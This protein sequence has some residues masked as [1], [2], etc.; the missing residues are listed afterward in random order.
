MTFTPL[1]DDELAALRALDTP[2]VCNALE[3]LVPERRG[4]G[5]TVEQLICSY[6]D[7]PPMVGYA[8]TATIRAMH[9]P[10]APAA[11]VAATRLEYYEY[12]EQGPRPTI[13][14]IQ[15][16]D[17]IK[18]FGSFWGEVQSN[19]HKGLGSLGVIT[20]GCVRDIP[21]C[22]EGFQFISGSIKPSHAYV[23]AVDYDVDVTVSGMDVSTDD[24][25]HADMHGAVVIP[26]DVARNVPETAA[27][28]ARKEAVIIGASQKPGFSVDVL[29]EAFKKQEDIH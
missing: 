17:P 26:H 5:F 4:H 6:P 24:L 2:T 23:H 9:P 12:V 19:V 22:A 7:L 3:I 29:R 28:I 13:I 20:D 10:V 15:D 25:I 14:V 27:L 16:L 18:G 21:D 8:R 11:E 1:N